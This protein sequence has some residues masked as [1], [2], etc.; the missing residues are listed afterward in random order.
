MQTAVALVESYLRLNGYFTV[1]EYQV[2]H[3]VP[4]QIGRYET[5][6]DLDVLAVR[7]PWAAGTVLRH[8]QRAGE[9][10][11]EI[12]LADDPTLGFTPE[13]PDVLIAEVKE[14]AAELNRRLRTPEVLLAALRRVV[15]CDE[16]HIEEAAAEILKHGQ[17]TLRSPHGLVCRVRLVAFCGYVDAARPA[18]VL[19]VTLA[20]IV[21]F[22]QDRLAAY[23]PI[24]R[25]AQVTDP[26]LGLL[27]L[28]DKAGIAVQPR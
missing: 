6:T 23:R 10:R 22:I 4:G 14:G 17:A 2:Q 21:E 16:E 13:I 5:A 11:C 26:I 3:P 15:C 9:S 27:S 18:A 7:L 1:T 20:H 8:P 24:L 19:T 28:M 12:L 25:S